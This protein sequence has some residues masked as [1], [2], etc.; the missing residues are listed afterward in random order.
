[1]SSGSRAATGEQIALTGVL[2]AG[3]ILLGFTIALM[4]ARFGEIATEAASIAFEAR[5]KGRRHH[6]KPVEGP[7]LSA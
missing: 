4:A 5:R 6:S 2:A 1:M 7:F 3:S